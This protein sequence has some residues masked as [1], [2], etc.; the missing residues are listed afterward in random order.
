MRVCARVRICVCVRV[1]V[2]LGFFLIEV[3][4]VYRNI[5]TGVESQHCKWGKKG[6]QIQSRRLPLVVID[7]YQEP[8]QAQI[9][10]DVA[11]FVI[12]CHFCI[13]PPSLN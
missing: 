9:Q 13:P 1:C 2:P 10:C 6:S 5:K 7:Y 8:L 12:Y 4:S 11:H 3:R